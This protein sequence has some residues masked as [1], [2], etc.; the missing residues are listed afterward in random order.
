MSLLDSYTVSQIRADQIDALPDTCTI[1]APTTT[2]RAT[3][4]PLDTWG[5]AAGSVACRMR[6]EGVPSERLTAE[7]IAAPQTYVLSMAYD[8]TLSPAYRVV[9]GGGTYEVVGVIDSGSWDTV[10]RARVTK[11]VR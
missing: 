2:T 3:G 5:T 6:P 4:H 11:A 1:L 7:Q 8:G 9:Y 10:T